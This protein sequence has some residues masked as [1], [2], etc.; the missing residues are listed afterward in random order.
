[1][2]V[3]FEQVT[4]SCLRCLFCHAYFLH[5]LNLAALGYSL[6][7]F[8]SDSCALQGFQVQFLS[9]DDVAEDGIDGGGLFKEFLTLLLRELMNMDRCCSR[10]LNC[11][12]SLLAQ[13]L[14]HRDTRP[15]ALAASSGD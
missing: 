15:S 13:R 4:F 11:V 8:R 3:R 14:L 12:F 9:D 10:S 7:S 6:L 2:R 5:A 1:M